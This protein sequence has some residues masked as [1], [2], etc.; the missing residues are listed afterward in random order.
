M[1]TSCRN[2]INSNSVN[3]VGMAEK[4]NDGL[5]VPSGRL[6]RFAKFGLLTTGI[7]GSMIKNGAVQIASGRRP[8]LSSLLLTP[9]NARR[10]VKQLSQMR[11]A[12]MKL[13]QLLSMDSGDIIPPELAAILSALQANASAM[14][15]AQ[16]EEVLIKQWGKAWSKRIKSFDF[17]PIAA[18]SIGQVHRAVS[19]DGQAIAI[20]LQYPGLRKSIDSDVDN[21]AGLLSFSG[22][23]PSQVDL[24]SLLKDA[25]KQLHNETD[26]LREG[27]FL[28]RF[29]ELLK[30]EPQFCVPQW[31]EDL[32]TSDLLAMRFIDSVPMDNISD[33]PQD[34][35][36][37]IIAHLFA[38][39][40][41]ELFEFR[42]VQTDPNFAN[43]RYC[44]QTKQIVLLDFGAV[45]EYSIAT[46][47]QLKKLV[48]AAINSDESKI[49]AA[50]QALGYFDERTAAHHKAQVMQ[51]FNIAFE[52]QGYEGDYD[53]AQSDLPSRL[54]RLAFSL[55]GDPDFGHIPATSILLLQRKAAGLFL[56]AV[57]LGA[58]VNLNAIVKAALGIR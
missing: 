46:T 28:K 13:G 17:V 58:K 9:A 32:S 16:V 48:K 8:K 2:K 35:K 6:T 38:L 21:V 18:A 7:V 29:H 5:A 55:I 30:G 25:K 3:L 33:I 10:V 47:T 42:M 27:N 24:K 1:T 23:V 12:A 41:R 45:Y 39:F 14:P 50:A 36:N 19:Q 54:N 40:M 20:K 26:Y 4:K 49:Q 15:S 53:F 11:G 31:D 44:I 56:L 51:I 43:Y 22:L 37:Q 34:Q 52:I 57:K